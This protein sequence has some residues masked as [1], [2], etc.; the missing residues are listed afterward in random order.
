MA[1]S[2][3]IIL[4]DDDPDDEELLRDV[5]Q[6]LNVQNRLLYFDD[7]LKAFDFLKITSEKPLI[8][9]SDIN[10]HR[11]SG[12]D[13]KRQIDTDPVLRAK[14]IPFVFFSTS[15]D[16]RTV[17]AA[18]KELTVQGFFEKPSSLQGLTRVIKVIIDYWHLCRHPNV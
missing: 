8:I 10:L 13:F 12:I 11:Q 16:K 4:V 15:T 9:L 3:P 14:S 18:F 7:C 6:E 1:I 17:D 2:G 5:L